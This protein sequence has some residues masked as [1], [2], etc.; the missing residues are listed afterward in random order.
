MSIVHVLP[1]LFASLAQGEFKLMLC[2]KLGLFRNLLDRQFIE[3][4]KGAEKACTLSAKK[5][6]KRLHYEAKNKT[7]NECRP[8]RTMVTAMILVCF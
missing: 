2:K 5:R 6:K 3:D 7:T 4:S 1:L 8:I